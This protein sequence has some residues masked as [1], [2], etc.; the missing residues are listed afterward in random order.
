MGFFHDLGSLLGDAAN[1]R[2]DIMQTA[3][4]LKA[5]VSE[6]AGDMRTVGEDVVKSVQEPI[7]IIRDDT[8][9]AVEDF[10]STLGGDR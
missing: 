7:E 6:T 10:K 3:E 1:I 2:E 9:S 8:T 4:D 5:T